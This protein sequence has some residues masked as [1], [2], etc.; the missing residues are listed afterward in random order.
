MLLSVPCESLRSKNS[1]SSYSS[2]FCSSASDARA[3]V[4]LR[5]AAATLA[6]RRVCKFPP[7]SEAAKRA[8]ADACAAS[9]SESTVERRRSFK[10]DRIIDRRER[11]GGR[12]ATRSESEL[13]IVARRVGPVPGRVEGRRCRPVG[14]GRRRICRASS[15]SRFIS[16]SLLMMMRQ[17]LLMVCTVILQISLMC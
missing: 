11:P 1:P 13:S 6:A 4:F 17:T 10:L 14:V 5:L 16:I 8:D 7:P 12:A 2:S 15:P 3:R 9:S